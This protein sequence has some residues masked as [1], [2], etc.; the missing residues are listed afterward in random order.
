MKILN[1]SEFG[2]KVRSW[3]LENQKTLTWLADEMGVSVSYVSDI[4]KGSR[5]SER[6]IAEIK[7]LIGM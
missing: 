5:K 4:L 1:Y 2:L 6:R 7:K 3:L